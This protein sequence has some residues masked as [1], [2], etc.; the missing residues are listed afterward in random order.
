[1]HVVLVEFTAAQGQRDALH[2]RLLAQ[3]ADSLS[4]EPECHQ[5][6]VITD[7]ENPDIF[8]LYEIYTDGAAFEHHLE[9]AHFINFAAESEAMVSQK[10]VRRLERSEA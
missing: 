8:V 3:A 7:P 4:L 9:T 2:A 10:T 1:M 5:F 6:D